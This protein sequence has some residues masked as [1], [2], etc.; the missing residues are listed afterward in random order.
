METYALDLGFDADES[1]EYQGR[2]FPLQAGLVKVKQPTGQGDPCWFTKLRSEDQL[3]FRVWDISSSTT[4]SDLLNLWVV[5]FEPQS[6][7]LL[8]D[9]ASD[10]PNPL[11][12]AGSGLYKVDT[13]TVKTSVYDTV[14]AGWVLFEATS[15]GLAFT[16]ADVTAPTR[17]VLQVRVEVRT[18]AGDLRSYVYDPEIVIGPNG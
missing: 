3:Y 13:G 5:F 7:S 11:I 6:T 8:A 15:L 9:S 17:Y 1:R 16:L 10:R 18:S 14:R 2:Y 12:C 4:G